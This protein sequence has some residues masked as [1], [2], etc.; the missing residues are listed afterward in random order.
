MN[1]SGITISWEENSD[2]G[3]DIHVDGERKYA[4]YFVESFLTVEKP[5]SVHFITEKQANGESA[6]DSATVALLSNL[7]RIIRTSYKTK[8]RLITERERDLKFPFTDLIIIKKFAEIAGIKFDEQKFQN[9]REFQE[10][11]KTL[12]KQV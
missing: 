10:Y 1:Q 9:R 8:G 12:V 3:Y 6:E 5:S 7:L 2:G 11:F 4:L